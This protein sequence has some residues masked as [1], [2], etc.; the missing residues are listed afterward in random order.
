MGRGRR[1]QPQRIDA[2]RAVPY[3]RAVICHP[4]AELEGLCASEFYG[5]A[6]QLDG[7]VQRHRI[8]FVGPRN[9][10]WIVLEKPIVRLLDLR[11]VANRLSENSVFIA[12]AVADGGILKR[13][14]R[15]DEAG[16]EAPEPAVA[17]ARV[18][19]LL[20]QCVEVPALLLHRLPTIGSAP[21]F[22]MLL[23]S[24][25]PSRNSIDR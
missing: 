13:R 11:A 1:P 5:G 10:P 17:E 24:V 9:L 25:R 14:Q 8:D 2:L 19:L 7:R 20:D 21:R 22:M 6:A 16:R 3:D 4:R 15:V 18:R 23:R 12:K